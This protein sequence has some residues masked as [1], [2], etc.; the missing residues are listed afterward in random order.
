MARAAVVNQGASN[1]SNTTNH[2]YDV[3]TGPIVVNGV[4]SRRDGLVVGGALGEGLRRSI[5]VSRGNSGLD[6]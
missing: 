3:D 1:T 2:N 6:Q 5:M 4:N